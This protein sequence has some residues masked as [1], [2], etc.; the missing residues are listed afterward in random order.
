MEKYINYNK[1]ISKISYNW[2]QRK[3]IDMIG[4]VCMIKYVKKI[5]KI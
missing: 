1:T 2:H 3:K 5:R 4:N